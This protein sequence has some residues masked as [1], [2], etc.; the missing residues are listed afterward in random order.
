MMVPFSTLLSTHIRFLLQSLD[1]SNF[2]SLFP[3]LCKVRLFSFHYL[4]SLSLFVSK[5]VCV[6][7]LGLL[8]FRKE[9]NKSE[10]ICSSVNG[11]C[12]MLGCFLRVYSNW[13][14]R[15][16]GYLMLLAS[17]LSFGD[18]FFPV[19]CRGFPLPRYK[20]VAVYVVEMFLFDKRFR[21]SRGLLVGL[22]VS[23]WEAD[24]PDL[25]CLGFH[26]RRGLRFL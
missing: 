8:A 14:H 2:D 24:S 19:C 6:S 7:L 10:I 21:C 13:L 11:I 26:T 3:E 16:Y 12:T 25:S 9:R 1:V 23:D 5:F 15:S 20:S 17:P 4:S 22:F 18:F